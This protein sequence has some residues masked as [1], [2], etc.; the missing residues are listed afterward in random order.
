MWSDNE[1][2]TGKARKPR[3]PWN[4]ELSTFCLSTVAFLRPYQYVAGSNESA[5]TW[6]EVLKSLQDNYPGKF[7]ELTIEKARDH[8]RTNL[9]A[10][11]TVVKS[12]EKASG[13]VEVETDYKRLQDQIIADRA[14]CVSLHMAKKEKDKEK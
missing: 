13:V 6:R 9:K 5:D 11:D 3:F 10:R 2:T 8:V 7:T 12:L 14:D 1:N 4:P